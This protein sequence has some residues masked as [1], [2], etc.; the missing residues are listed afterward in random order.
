MAQKDKIMTWVEA[1]EECSKIDSYLLEP[2]NEELQSVAENFDG[3][4]IG[5]SDILVE[6][7]WTWE[8]NGQPLTYT[9]WGPGQP[10]N[11]GSQDCAMIDAQLTWQDVECGGRAPFVCQTEKHKQSKFYICMSDREA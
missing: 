5:A 11:Y 2:R 9:N 1:V 7:N 6:G 3:S 8:S 4:W 10:N